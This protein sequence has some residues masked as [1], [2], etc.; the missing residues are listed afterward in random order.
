MSFTQLEQHLACSMLL[1]EAEQWP[2]SAESYPSQE[3]IQRRLEIASSADDAWIETCKAE[4]RAKLARSDVRVELI[5]RYLLH[6]GI[7]L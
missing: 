4:L 6:H 3:A 5:R 7:A 1:L 2:P